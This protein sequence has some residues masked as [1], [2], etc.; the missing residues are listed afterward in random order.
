MFGCASMALSMQIEHEP[1]SDTEANRASITAWRERGD[2]A[3]TD[4]FTQRAA[5]ALQEG[6][7]ARTR[8]FATLTNKARRE[9]LTG[10]EA[11]ELSIIA[12]ELD[13]AL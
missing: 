7:E 9:A 5:A 11:Y 12:T 3:V 2:E 10:S 1:S 13:A 6:L 4:T 8:R